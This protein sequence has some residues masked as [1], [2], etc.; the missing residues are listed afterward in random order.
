[1]AITKYSNRH[2]LL[3][4]PTIYSISPK[5]CGSKLTFDETLRLVTE[6]AASLLHADY[7]V[8]MMLNPQTRETVKTVY[9]AM[10]S[11]Q[12]KNLSKIPHDLIAGWMFQNHRQLV[13]NDIQKDKRFQNVDFSGQNLSVLGVLAP[14]R[15][16]YGGRLWCHS[17]KPD[18]ERVVR[19]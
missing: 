15:A 18:G 4:T 2:C 16:L 10:R 7:S 6:Q 3:T 17:R 8:V 13:S 19:P 1:L 14:G 11:E 5:Y 9:K 12:R